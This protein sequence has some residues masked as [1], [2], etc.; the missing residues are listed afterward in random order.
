MI[1][2]GPGVQV[3]ESVLAWDSTRDNVAE[4]YIAKRNLDHD[5]YEK[6]LNGPC[7]LCPLPDGSV[8]EPRE[9]G[10]SIWEL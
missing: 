1:D 6:E 3:P 5:D 2:N 4:V 8:C 7:D 10:K 9:P